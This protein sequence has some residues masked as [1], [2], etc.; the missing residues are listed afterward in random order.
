MKHNGLCGYIYNV[1]DVNEKDANKEYHMVLE[2]TNDV[3]GKDH[4]IG[5]WIYLSEVRDAIDKI[6]NDPVLYK[7]YMDKEL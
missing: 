2:F 4:E 3:L 7:R 1:E 5:D 6:L